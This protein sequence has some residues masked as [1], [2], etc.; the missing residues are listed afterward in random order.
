MKARPVL[1]QNQTQK[2]YAKEIG[3]L[4][5]SARVKSLVLILGLTQA[6][7]GSAWCYVVHY[8]SKDVLPRERKILAKRI[9]QHVKDGR[10]VLAANYI[11]RLEE[12]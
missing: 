12:S 2:K 8:S 7:R 1:K 10:W 11:K 6:G 4:Y 9:T 3:K 5:Y